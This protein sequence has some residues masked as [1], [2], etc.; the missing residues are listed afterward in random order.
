MR[1]KFFDPPML[2]GDRTSQE[3]VPIDADADCRRRGGSGPLGTRRMGASD[4]PGMFQEKQCR[5]D[6]DA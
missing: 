3:G 2:I 1:R 4:V 6:S 5:V